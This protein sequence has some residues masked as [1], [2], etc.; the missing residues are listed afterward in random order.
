[1]FDP[2]APAVSLASLPIPE[3]VDHADVDAFP[4]S[5]PVPIVSPAVTVTCPPTPLLPEPTD[6]VI[7]PPVPVDP[8][9]DAI[10]VSPPFRLHYLPLQFEML[11]FL[12]LCHYLNRT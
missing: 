11:D 12:S 6:A 2:E 10:D 1:M 4:P 7:A 3:G 8:S 5:S 9:P